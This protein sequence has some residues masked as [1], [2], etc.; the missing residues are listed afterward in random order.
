MIDNLISDISKLCAEH[1]FVRN[2]FRDGEL[3]KESLRE[4][5]RMIE[6]D[7]I[8]ETLCEGIREICYNLLL[9]KEI[10]P[11]HC[12]LCGPPGVGKSTIARHLGKIF[13]SLGMLKSISIK[14]NIQDQDKIIEDLYGF[15]H[16]S[17]KINLVSAEELWKKLRHQTIADSSTHQD[18]VVTCGKK[19]FVADYAGQTSSKTFNFLIENI[20]KC[21][22]IEEAYSLVAGES[23]GYGSESLTVI[24]RFMEE[25]SDKIIIIMTG[26]RDFLEQSIL[27]SQKGLQRRFLWIFEIKGYT[28]NGLLLMFEQLL[29]KKGWTHN[30][31]NIQNFFENNYNYFPN[32][33]GD[34]KKFVF[35]CRAVFANSE[36]MKISERLARGQNLD[37]PLIS[38]EIFEIAFE[39]YKKL[40]WF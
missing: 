22:I 36:C 1:E 20:G 21:I 7:N 37:I 5:D 15:Y 39:K 35:S 14:K 32:F 40:N 30:I 18:F 6:L 2:Q 38:N 28:P 23:D 8:K 27:K 33:G 34:V 12:L 13:Y 16:N 24:N 4:F 3:L 29:D 10:E 19:D 11:F 9:H 25:Y 17:R 26:Y 31:T